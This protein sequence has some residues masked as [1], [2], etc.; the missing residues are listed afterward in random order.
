MELEQIKTAVD[1]DEALQPSF[2]NFFGLDYA[3]G[4][5]PILSL[6]LYVCMYVCMLYY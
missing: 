6:I 3:I 1:A 2:A 5:N 4:S